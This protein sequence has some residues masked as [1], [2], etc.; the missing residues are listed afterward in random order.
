MLP[1]DAPEGQRPREGAQFLAFSVGHAH[2]LVVPQD[3]GSER[4]AERHHNCAGFVDLGRERDFNRGR[5]RKRPVRTLVHLQRHTE[6]VQERLE[7]G[8]WIIGCKTS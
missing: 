6:A 3:V 7:R 1:V 8:G 5:G 4:Q 2:Q